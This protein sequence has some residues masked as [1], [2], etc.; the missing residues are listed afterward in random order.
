MMVV[1]CVTSIIKF[2]TELHK[3]HGHSKQKKPFALKYDGLAKY[4]VPECNS[5]TA[6]YDL[7]IFKLSNK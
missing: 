7:T 2:G 1:R 6:D 3:K 4:I 5:C